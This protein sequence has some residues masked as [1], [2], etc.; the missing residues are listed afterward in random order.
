M[1][2]K[3]SVKDAKIPPQTKIFHGNNAL[4]LM[5][6]EVIS[7]YFG[8]KAAKEVQAILNRKITEEEINRILNKEYTEEQINE[9][10]KKKVF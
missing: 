2:I 9:I 8:E 10:L 1:D 6:Q 3:I 5:L 4:E 7:K